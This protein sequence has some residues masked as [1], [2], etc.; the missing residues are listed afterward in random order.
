MN[1]LSKNKLHSRLRNIEVSHDKIIVGST[2]EALAYSYLNNIPFVSARTAAPY[3]FERFE[4]DVDLAVFNFK[5]EI[6]NLKTNKVSLEM[7]SLKLP[8]WEKLYFYLNLSGLCIKS[9]NVSSLRIHDGML[10][11]STSNA[12]LIKASYNELIV[13]D[14]Y[15]LHG[16]PPPTISA[17]KFVVYDWF[18]VKSGM[19][20][21]YDLIHDEKDFIREII[22]YPSER[23]MG[24]HNLKDA[25]GVSFLTKKQLEDFE[26]SDI[27]ARFKTLYMMKEAGIKGARNGRDVNDKTRYKY[28]SVKLET[29]SRDIKFPQNLYDSSDD[30]IFIYSSLHDIINQNTAKKCY[31]SNLARRI[32]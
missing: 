18:N 17:D 4:P 29:V 30:I 8:L 32:T 13:F 24:E 26:Y 12:R 22:F 2:L 10:K 15:N 28:Y 19:K 31:V 1:F 9:N 23:I 7:G 16:L 11:I 5:N 14:D 25:V 20:H 27:N 3:F 6:K 21:E